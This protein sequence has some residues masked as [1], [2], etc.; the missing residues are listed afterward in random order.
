MSLPTHLTVVAEVSAKPGREEE[1]KLLILS[2]IDTVRREDGCIQ[3]DLH[4]A[5][6]DPMGFLFFENW[7]N[8]DALQK[9]LTSGHMRDF[10]SRAADLTLGPPRVVTY[11]R[12]A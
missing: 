7:K 2:I 5:T 9:H 11:T 1:L 8:G 12:V 10:F 6:N 4:I 3:Y